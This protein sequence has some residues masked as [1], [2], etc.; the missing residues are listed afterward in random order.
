MKS[1][2]ILAVTCHCQIEGSELEAR[3][4]GILEHE[5]GNDGHISYNS[6]GFLI[7]FTYINS[8]AV[9]ASSSIIFAVPFQPF[10]LLYPHLPLPSPLAPAP[11]MFLL[12]DYIPQLSDK[13]A[14]LG[15]ALGLEHQVRNLQN[16]IHPPDRCMYSLLKDWVDAGDR[17]VSGVRVDVSWAFLVR[18]LRSPAVGKGSVATTIENSYIRENQ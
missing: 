3:R 15:T 11:S 17:V 9:V 7:K 8:L 18:V 2:L 5:Q 14:E 13:W 10:Q 12:Q 6:L 1:S 4:G 16:S